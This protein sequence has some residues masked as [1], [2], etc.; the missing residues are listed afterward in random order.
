[1]ASSKA[2][3]TKTAPPAKIISGLPLRETA[4][5]IAVCSVL[6]FQSLRFESYE[7][8]KLAILGILVAVIIGAAL[9]PLLSKGRPS[10]G[11]LRA[12][13]L[14]LAVGGF[15]VV[16]AISTAFS[17]NSAQS[18]LGSA[19]R[20]QGLIAL[21]LYAV[22]FWAASRA[23][24]Q[25]RAALPPV[26]M[27]ITIPIC[28]YALLTAAANGWA[29]EFAVSTTGNTNY[30]ASWL[31]ISLLYCVPA[32]LH[33]ISRWSRPF[34]AEQRRLLGLLIASAVLTVATLVVC[35]SRGALLGLALG[36]LTGAILFAAQMRR[37]KAVIGIMAVLLLAGVL[38]LVAGR[39]VPD[40]APF[41]RLLRP[42]D[43]TRVTAWNFA[44]EQII[45]QAEPL[46]AADGSTDTWATL[47]PFLGFGLENIDQIQI[48]FGDPFSN[49]VYVDHF[50]NLIFDTLLMQ[51]WLGLLT[52]AAIYLCA[53]GLSLHMLGMLTR[54]TL[55]Q[56]LGLQLLGAV[57]GVIAVPVIIGQISL[58]GGAPIG[59][60]LGAVL[61]TLL[62]IVVQA[63]RTK[64][65]PIALT[66]RHITII[67]TLCIIVAQW[68]DNQFG[69][70]QIVTQTLW[71]II[72]GGLLT[73]R[74]TSESTTETV[75]EP[76]LWYGAVL[77]IGLF[78]LAG[79]GDPIQ[80]NSLRNPVGL[81]EL[82]VLLGGVLF[83]AL[84]GAL[85]G[86]FPTVRSKRM[87]QIGRPIITVIGIWGAFFAIKWLLTSLSGSQFDNFLRS[88]VSIKS[89]AMP[90]TLLWLSLIGILAT[91]IG[92][93]G[94][95]RINDLRK[96]QAAGLLTLAL[97]TG[98]GCAAYAYQLT[99]SD[100]HHIAGVYTAQGEQISFDVADV[101]YESSLRIAPYN[102]QA[103]VDWLFSLVTRLQVPQVRAQMLTRIEEETK[104]L[105]K[106]APYYQ[107]TRTWQLFQKNL[108][109]LNKP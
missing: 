44:A 59:A 4:L 23:N 74:N 88:G 11:K 27:L 52:L 22:L 2:K 54:A 12:N 80:S 78:L 48:R 91:L 38:Y 104:A 42:Y 26:L 89:P 30:L 19:Y 47:R 21:L 33:Q 68:V 99:A 35:G 103:R 56:W 95:I 70:T 86:L 64:A 94:L 36:A 46:K 69:F 20:S 105:L 14:V 16:T 65:E 50:H 61:G 29:R 58:G 77:A 39:I 1:M 102:V 62:W 71:W 28:L 76:H 75:I 63:L 7:S 79:L 90:G 13:P 5:L 101:A 98:A 82:P 84:V 17:L 67:A 3:K 8:E 10:I 49:T 60:A 66:S 43:E 96:M 34:S 93:L 9:A 57:L 85:G 72:L 32:W 81:T 31:V 6:A 106:I 87:E 41:A 53:A 108:T 24:D 40:T 18:L 107:N 25:F 92:L 100:L 73:L 109:E 83:G 97:A 51:G 37:R 45:R 55:W 15:L